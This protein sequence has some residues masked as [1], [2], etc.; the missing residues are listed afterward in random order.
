MNSRRSLLKKRKKLAWDRCNVLRDE[1]IEAGVSFGFETVGSHPSKV[2][3]LQNA[4][5]LPDYFSVADTASIWDNSEEGS[6]KNPAIKLLVEKEDGNP[7]TITSDAAEVTW[8]R[9][10]LLSD[11]LKPYR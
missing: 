8:I 10:H 1:L 7:V 9:K 11:L 4:K 6:S 2:K 3:L 5:L